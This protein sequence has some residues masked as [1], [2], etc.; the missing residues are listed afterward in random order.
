MPKLSAPSLKQLRLVPYSFPERVEQHPFTQEAQAAGVHDPAILAEVWRVTRMAYRQDKLYEQPFQKTFKVPTVISK[1]TL[2]ILSVE[3][4]KYVAQQVKYSLWGYIRSDPRLV[5]Y[6]IPNSPGHISAPIM[7]DVEAEDQLVIKITGPFWLQFYFTG[8]RAHRIYGHNPAAR[9]M[10]VFYGSS[11]DKIVTPSVFIPEI[12]PGLYIEKAIADV[13][14]RLGSIINQEIDK[15]LDEGKQLAEI[16]QQV[17]EAQNYLAAEQRYIKQIKVTQENQYALLDIQR[18]LNRAG[19]EMSRILGEL[20]R[21]R[22]MD[23]FPKYKRNFEELEEPTTGTFYRD[24]NHELQVVEVPNPEYKPLGK[25]RYE[26]QQ[27]YL[28][29]LDNYLNNYV[30]Q[31]ELTGANESHIRDIIA[32][33]HMAGKTASGRVKYIPTKLSPVKKRVNETINQ[34]HAMGVKIKWRRKI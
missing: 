30:R 25:I 28:E 20:R 34:L 3:V 21:R 4:K 12:K 11:G 22:Q 19:A 7:V 32:P 8:A 33:E 31:L 15:E 17:K 26:L 18:D 6:L 29:A 10:L 13:M 27:K 5:K 2:P 24:K 14:G 16:D 23:F 1:N 9:F